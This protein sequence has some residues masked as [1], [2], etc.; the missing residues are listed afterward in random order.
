MTQFDSMSHSNK[1]LFNVTCVVPFYVIQVEGQTNVSMSLHHTS[2]K[3]IN[4]IFKAITGFKTKQQKEL[5][6]DNSKKA[7]KEIVSKIIDQYKCLN[8]KMKD[9]DRCLWKKNILMGEKCQPLPFQD[10]IFYDDK[11]NR[12]FESPYSSKRSTLS[13]RL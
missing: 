4:K 9:D 1:T 12:L 10:A 7:I 11:G 8:I 3:I 5:T 13:L 2:K 6:P